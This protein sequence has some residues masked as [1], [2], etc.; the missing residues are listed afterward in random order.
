MHENP[1]RTRQVSVDVSDLDTDVMS[2]SEVVA[3]ITK[4]METTQDAPK[5][6][7]RNAEDVRKDRRAA[8]KEAWAR[9]WRA[10]L[11][12]SGTLERAR[13]NPMTMVQ[14][15]GVPEFMWDMLGTKLWL[16]TTRATWKTSPARPWSST[17]TS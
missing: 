12:S 15:S 13:T 2:P 4:R 3:E 1:Q 9:E 14:V 10:A 5:P 17:R 7:K 8:F 6:S 16:R 11:D